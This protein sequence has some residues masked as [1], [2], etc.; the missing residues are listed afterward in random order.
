MLIH[1]T[2]IAV[3]SLALAAGSA[4]AQCCGGKDNRD[5][6]RAHTHGTTA[7]PHN[8]KASDRQVAMKQAVNEICPVGKE[9]IDGRTFITY[10][11]DVVGFCCP[12]C[13]GQFLGW[14]K[15]RRDA[16]IRT[17]KAGPAEAES[18]PAAAPSPTRRAGDRQRADTLAALYPLSTCPVSGEPLG[19]MGDPVIT[20]YGDREVR[21]CCAAC[22]PQFEEDRESYLKRIDEQIIATHLPYYPLESCI[23]AGGKLGSM[24][25]PDNYIYQNRLVRFC[26][27]G[28]RG[29]FDENATDFLTRLDKA[30][31]DEQRAAYPM[32]TCIV[33]GNRLGSMGDPAEVILAGRL[34]RL[35]CPPCERELR[36]EPATYIT[37][38]DDAWRKAGRPGLA[39]PALPGVR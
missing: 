19:S 1:T 31:A 18:A 7:Q 2:T 34:V 24:G 15:D 38:L 4:A 36:H 35:C 9:P 22:V 14:N 5:G 13:E 26:C 32:Q 21:F 12:G 25:E 30:A 37:Q 10:E 28:C 8:Q 17:A 39:Q 11:G 23:V 29:Q 33:R 27:A 6:A 3:L 20:M 16:F